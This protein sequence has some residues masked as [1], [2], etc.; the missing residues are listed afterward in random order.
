MSRHLKFRIE[1]NHF[2]PRQCHLQ[3]NVVASAGEHV[4]MHHEVYCRA[5]GGQFDE[6]SQGQRCDSDDIVREHEEKNVRGVHFT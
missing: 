6:F 1:I 5:R 4:L 3:W 2:W